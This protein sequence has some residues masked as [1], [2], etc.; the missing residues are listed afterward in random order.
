MRMTDSSDKI[1]FSPPV[2]V[3]IIIGTVGVLASANSLYLLC[4]MITSLLIIH[5]LWKN[6]KPGILVFA[7]LMQ[8]VQVIAY[9][10][11]MNNFNMDINHLSKHAG[12]AVVFACVGLALMAATLSSRLKSLRMPSPDE[13]NVQAR[14]IDEKKILIL[15]LISTFFL[16]GLGF[17]FGHNPGFFQIL[18]TLSSLKWVFFMVYGY[19]AW[20][21]KKNRFTL[22]LIIVFEF[23]TSLYAYFSTFKEVIYFTI[24]LSLS[25]VR[26]INFK[27]LIYGIVVTVSL[28]FLLLTWTAIKSDY[29]KFLNQGT[30]QQVVE[31]SRS[32]AFSKIEEKV[33]ALTWGDYQKVLGLFLYRA[34]YIL[35]L[36]R[37]MDM[38]PELLP[39]EY[40]SIW[41]G[42]ISFVLMP[43]LFFPDKPVYEATVKTNKYTGFRYSGLKEGASFSLG[44]FA[45]SYIDFGYI[46]MFLPL[47]LI[48]LF[49]F[50]IYKTI[51]AFHKINVLMRYAVINVTLF[52]FCSFES[53]GLFLFGRL[54]LMFLVYWFLCKFLLGYIQAWL[55]K[56]SGVSKWVK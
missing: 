1:T 37:T 48:A 54:L 17:A 55:Y 31:V 40:G 49:V 46:G 11:W 52:D 24:I 5:F 38:V 6:S 43:R 53:D 35:H 8:W 32:Q 42:N 2:L 28:L 50:F 16:G 18:T 41:W 10:L 36:S 14:L 3:A 23:T 30:N 15:Y 9:V 12:V 39:H 56:P 33:G 25:F 34:Q 21:N 7:L 19:V 27:Q 29:R 22:A 51:Y 45:D 13:L 20:I 26:H 4:C 44:Y 47:F